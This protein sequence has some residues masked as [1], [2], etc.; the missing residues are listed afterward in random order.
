MAITP[1]DISAILVDRIEA[2]WP[3]PG[4]FDVSETDDWPAEVLPALLNQRIIIEVS[5]SEAITCPG[6]EWQC[7]KAVVVRQAGNGTRA[8]IF[9]NEEPD[10]GRVPVF[11]DRL[12]R[13]ATDLKALATLFADKLKVDPPKA[14]KNQS[15]Y[16]L[17]TITGRN[18]ARRLAIAIEDGQLVLCVGVQREPLTRVL[19]CS[20]SG[21]L[22]DPKLVRHL[23][24][25]KE[26]PTQQQRQYV[27]DRTGQAERK[28]NTLE[29]DR[30]IFREAKEQRGCIGITWTAVAAEIAKSRGLSPARVRRIITE[31]RGLERKNSRSKSRGNN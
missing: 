24:N 29:R 6:C 15:A 12:Q 9:C 17:G 13:F 21:L 2:A 30:A 3:A 8:F 26:R 1:R 22:V 19:S 16:M 23:A 28:N 10:L 7:H 20:E 18:G 31:Q 27:P 5:R 4:Y 14:S 25:R 11:L